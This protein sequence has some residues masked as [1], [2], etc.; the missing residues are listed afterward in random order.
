MNLA[1]RII[2]FSF[3][4]Y[5]LNI[6][7][8]VT[9][10]YKDPTPPPEDKQGTPAIAAN[11]P[12]TIEKPL[13]VYETFSKSKPL[14]LNIPVTNDRGSN[15][16]ENTVNILIVSLIRKEMLPAKTSRIEFIVSR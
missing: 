2:I 10:S 5:H 11:T 4:Y 12:A 15:I 7:H 13:G 1:S 3:F 8:I 16:T 14:I 6:Y 9:L